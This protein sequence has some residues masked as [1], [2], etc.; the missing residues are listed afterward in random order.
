MNLVSFNQLCEHVQLSAWTVRRLLAADQ[1]P[2]PLT[3][4]KTQRWDI[5]AV[6]VFIKQNQEAAVEQNC[7]NQDLI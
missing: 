5:D 3:I 6:D 2:P 7:S 1:L 4:G